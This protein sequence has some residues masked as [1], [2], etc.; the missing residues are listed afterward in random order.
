[1]TRR[2]HS[3]APVC[4]ALAVLC[5][6][7]ARAGEPASEANLSLRL[8]DF[9]IEDPAVRRVVERYTIHREMEQ[10]RFLGRREYEEFLLDRLPLAAALGK[11]LHEALEPYNIVE[12][13]PGLYDVDDRGA[14]RGHVRLVANA[15][16]RRIYLVEGQF[17][18]LAQLLK[19]DG[20]MIITLAYRDEEDGGPVLVNAPQLYLRLDN[21][22]AH[23]IL[24]VLAPLVHGVIDRR[25][26]HL[27][28]AA[29]R[30]SARITQ[31]PAG[32]YREMRAWPD[33][34]D[35]HRA[36]FRRHFGLPEDP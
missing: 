24:K 2:A 16:G 21:I 29:E 13:A 33:V 10:V 30:V 9:E 18:S 35:A 26:A 6:L 22:L 14:L 27:A 31:D 11:R 8:L 23:G 17:R 3:L 7:P 19:L 25:F 28:G 4:L 32:V 15:P 34:T 12:K 36:D 20:T 1:M 5:A